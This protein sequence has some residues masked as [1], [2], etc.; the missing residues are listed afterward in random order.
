MK[1]Y[2]D[3]QK[4][5]YSSPKIQNEIIEICGAIILGKIISKINQAKFFSI[6]A[7]E[8]TDISGIEQFSSCVRYVEKSDKSEILR[9]D[10]LKFVPVEDVTGFGLAN[11][12]K[13][14]CKDL[15]LNL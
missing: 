15:T 8:T 6:L 1:K 3:T 12:L 14:T 5:Q 7:D 13:T 11:K 10:F 2:L 9:E 4:L